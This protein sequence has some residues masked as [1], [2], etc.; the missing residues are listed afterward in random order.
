M[1]NNSWHSRFYWAFSLLVILER[2]FSCA[3][4]AKA[5]RRFNGSHRVRSEQWTTVT[6]LTQ[7]L[8]R[9]VKIKS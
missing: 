1:L 5:A 2:V 9:E 7:M 6:Q 3:S 8:F 4:E